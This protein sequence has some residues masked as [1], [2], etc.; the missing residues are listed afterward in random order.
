MSIR[1]RPELDKCRKCALY[2]AATQAVDGE[3]PI[4]AEVMF[5]GEAPGYN[6]DRIGRPFVGKAGAVLDSI[7]REVRLP[8]RDVY[9]SNIVKHQP[10]G[11]RDPIP[12][13]IMACK[14][15]LDEEVAQVQPK[16]I[17][18]LGGI[19]AGRYF[20]AKAKLGSFRALAD[21]TVVVSTY[22]PAF[23][24]RARNPM[25]RASIVKM[26]REGLSCVK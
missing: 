5:I 8:R 22:H 19:A 6:E 16:L 21:G 1:P 3:G 26:I 12:D 17:V 14:D 2:R 15:F 7:L 4:P 25:V 9:I 23:F 20:P 11:N 18:C 13:E 10:P 24:L